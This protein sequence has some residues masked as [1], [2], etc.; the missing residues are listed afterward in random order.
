MKDDASQNIPLNCEEIQELLF[1]YMS[2][3]L[4]DGRSDLVR[5]HLRKCKDCQSAL[6]EME[7]TIDFLRE[8]SK[9]TVP[10]SRLSDK[11]HARLVR[12]LTHPVLDWVYVHH[13]IV[14]LIIALLVLG[15]TFGVLRKT[16]IWREINMDGAI[17]VFLGSP[18]ELET[19]EEPP[20]EEPV[21]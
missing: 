17:Q 13:M 11:H 19:E 16:K 7:F 3:E 2:R 6:S 4:G 9:I 15:I 1:E 8:T 20:G 14:S 10:P 21:E 12:A 18:P 5:E